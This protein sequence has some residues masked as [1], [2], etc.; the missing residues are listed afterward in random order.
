M[1]DPNSIR[2]WHR[3][4]DDGRL[5]EAR[6]K[7]FNALCKRGPCT[8]QEL[9]SFSGYQHAEKRLSELE[10]QLVVVRLD[11]RTC[12]VTGETAATWDVIYDATPIQLE[13]PQITAAQRIALLEKAVQELQER[14]EVL[15]TASSPRQHLGRQI[16]LF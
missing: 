1:R 11:P 7:T 14:V 9:V 13:K 5:T 16:P 3:I 15:E 2:T 10:R 8:A 12:T 4:Q 6:L